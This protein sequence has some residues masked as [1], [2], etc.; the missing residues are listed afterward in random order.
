M[1]I[2]IL[3]KL[4]AGCVA[5]PTPELCE[6]LR[7]R[8]A[9]EAR[10]PVANYLLACDAFDRG[11]CASG[12]RSMMIAHHA[13]PTLESAALLVFAG[14]NWGKRRETP[15][16]EVLLDTWEEFRRPEFDRKRKERR[17][18]DA[19]A[20][21]HERLDGVSPLARRLW[22]LPIR[23]LR[24]QIREAVRSADAAPYSLLLTPATV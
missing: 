7:V 16:L 3:K 13:E 11:R 5:H 14:L 15:L 8:L 20:Q 6:K 10:C 17:L 12:V 1:E 18:L 22:R 23:T 19:F 24:D 2:A 9:S 21:P 4:G